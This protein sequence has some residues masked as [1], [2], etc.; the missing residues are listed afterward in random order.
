MLPN[1]GTVHGAFLLA[2]TARLN[3]LASLE[4][5]IEASRSQLTYLASATDLHA[6]AIGLRDL[7]LLKEKPCIGIDARLEPLSHAADHR[8]MIG[9]ARLLLEG[10]PPI[11][12]WSAVD[13]G[14]VLREYI[15]S[16]DLK[17]LNWLEPQLDA[18]L[19]SVHAK[20]E[21]ARQNDLIKQ[22]GDASEAILMAAFEL[23]GRRPI[24]VA[25]FH[26]G[27]GY[28]IELPST[29]IDRI[30]VKAA[31]TNTRGRFR[32]TRNEFDQ[33]R[34]LGSEW[35]LLQVVF[36]PQAF[37]AGSIGARHVLEVIEITSSNVLQLAPPDSDAFRWVES[38]EFT[39]HP[40]DWRKVAI[41]L[42]PTFYA[43]GFK[44]TNVNV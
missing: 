36:S 8:T 17:A 42:D 4:Q 29:P 41:K 16:N 25:K 27:C 44:R 38:A 24:H 33:C 5:L 22:I 10:Y 15:P 14:Q 20:L 7:K 34:L 6:P 13:R 19:K 2:Y 39:P 3:R 37:F 21:A 35:R 18:L 28:D 9:I 1:H 32:L 11:W 40:A 43:P 26:D 30:E 31:S 23:E 12:L